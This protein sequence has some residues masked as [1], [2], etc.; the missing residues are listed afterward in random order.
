MVNI[1]NCQY[2]SDIF[3]RPHKIK[4]IWTCS[5]FVHHEHKFKLTA[6]LCGRFQYLKFKWDVFVIKYYY[7]NIIINLLKWINIK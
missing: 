1:K 4:I 3:F 5:N 2:N 6:W 7:K